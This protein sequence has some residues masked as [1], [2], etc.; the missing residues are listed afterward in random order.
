[1]GAIRVLVIDDSVVIRKIVTDILSEAPG[2]EV[3]GT[4]ANGKIG[5]AKIEQ[6]NPD[7]V[8]LDI[9]MPVMSGLEAL[10]EIRKLR[11]NMPVVMFSAST[12]L[13]AEATLDALALGAS[14]Y[15]AKPASAGSSAAAIESVRKNLIPK[16]NALCHR[17]DKP[18]PQRAHGIAAKALKES[19][20]PRRIELVAIGVSTG[21]PNALAAMM[22]HL[23]ADF[24]VPIVVV[25]HM[26]PVFT[27]YLAKR[28]D[29]ECK[30][31]VREGEAGAILEPGA[32]WIAPGGLHMI[33]ARR[34][35]KLVLELNEA[36]RENQ[37]RPA[38]DVLFR[39]AAAATG[40]RTLAVVMTG[41]GQ[42]G[43]HGCEEIRE[44]GGQ[45]IAQDEASSVVWGMPGFV[46]KAGLAD[47][48]LP[49]SEIAQA[50]VR[51]VSLGRS[52]A[53]GLAN[54]GN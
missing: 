30:V 34:G 16:I 28:L 52:A 27:G 8:T 21:G 32:C 4:A 14:D 25:Q 17:D 29:S 22:P 54:H 31:G 13:G 7:L 44:Q 35:K 50:I 48:T 39:S 9:E 43:L 45:I 1:M 23:P 41:M 5:L 20:S 46:S 26:P 10:P 36:P 19:T 18:I 53:K 12:G 15:V 42:D 51:R 40:S 47:E 3:A 6:L 37:C 33:V 2:I 38:V 49:L 24:P 11:P